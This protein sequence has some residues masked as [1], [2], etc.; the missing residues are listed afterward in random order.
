MIHGNSL[1]N[2]CLHSRKG[3]SVTQGWSHLPPASDFGWMHH[4]GMGQDAGPP[5][6]LYTG[7]MQMPSE[8]HPDHT[9]PGKWG[10]P[11]PS[12][13][14]DPQ[15]GTSPPSP[16]TAAGFWSHSFPGH[17][18]CSI[19]PAA[20]PATHPKPPSSPRYGKTPATSREAPSTHLLGLTP[21]QKLP[22]SHH[23]PSTAMQQP[24]PGAE[25]PPPPPA[26]STPMLLP[27]PPVCPELQHDAKGPPS[28]APAPGSRHGRGGHTVCHQ[29]APR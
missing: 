21:L 29:H 24:L 10:L 8:Q 20:A 13:V 17:P 12:S 7:T 9:S 23:L 2:P 19:P 11:G 16:C 18:P 25:G 26:H 27:H 1:P 14:P 15:P 6:C 5:Q 22:R 4:S 28:S 3:G